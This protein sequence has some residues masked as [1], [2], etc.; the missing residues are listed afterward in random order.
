MILDTFRQIAA[1][2]PHRPWWHAALIGAL[3]GY[4][5]AELGHRRNWRRR[6]SVGFSVL[7]SLLW[8]VYWSAWQ[9]L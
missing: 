5:C 6:D 8:S 2:F 9:W 1:D 7:W 3:A 4:Q